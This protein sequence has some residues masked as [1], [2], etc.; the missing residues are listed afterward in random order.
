MSGSSVDSPFSDR[1]W[2]LCFMLSVWKNLLPLVGEETSQR[3]GP[4]DAMLPAVIRA[5]PLAR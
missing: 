3:S 4:S 5:I 1:L 2:L